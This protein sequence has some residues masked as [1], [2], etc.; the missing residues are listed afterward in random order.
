MCLEANRVGSEAAGTLAVKSK[1]ALTVG[2]DAN[3]HH[4]LW[5]YRKEGGTEMLGTSMTP[6]ELRI[7]ESCITGRKREIMANFRF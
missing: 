4:S 3:R 6:L 5:R 1:Q 2:K 7:L